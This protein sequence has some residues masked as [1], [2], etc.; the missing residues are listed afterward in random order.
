MS[1]KPAQ[2]SENNVIK[3]KAFA[4]YSW[5]TQG[6]SDRVLAWCERLVSD[7]V[8]VEIDRWSLREGDDKFAYME[9]MVTDP[10]ISHVLIFSDRRYA[11]R[12]NE[13]THGVG[14]ESQIISAELYGKVV[15]DKFIPIACELDEKGE[16]IMPVFLK[17]R[18]YVDFSSPEKANENWEKLLRRIY[19]KPSATKPQLGKTPAYLQ[20]GAA[21]ASPSA[22]KFLSLKDAFQ[23]GH[24]NPQIWIIDYLDTA[25]LHV[26]QYPLS[27]PAN[28]SVADAATMWENSLQLMLPL[29]NELVGFIEL[30]FSAQIPEAAADN[31][32]E[33][34]ERLVRLRFRDARDQPPFDPELISFF[35][36]EL[37][38]YAV[39]AGIRFKRFDSV[40]LLLD[41]RYVI[42]ENPHR[43]QRSQDFTVMASF[44]RLLSNHNKSSR[45]NRLSMEAD[46]IQKRATLPAYPL[47]SLIEADVICALRVMTHLD[48]YGRWS[49]VTAVY[50]EY[51]STLDLF[52]RAEENRLFRQ[53]ALVIDVVDK[54]DLESRIESFNQRCP[55]HFD[56]LFRH[57]DISLAQL[58]GVDRL[59]TRGT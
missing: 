15:Q 32:G 25:L 57:G 40:K 6:H 44:S 56:W 47:P 34:F 55:D 35:G 14:A 33:L 24:P 43:R 45:L 31:I 26:Q 41:R 18:I 36:H 22:S 42:P 17:G 46:L 2:P 5:T 12:A 10:A 48:N 37:F 28:V 3:V 9:R 49:P 23:R 4:S 1:T 19:G 30:M 16:A 7:G 50:A 51:L 52:V 20:E 39:A 59:A 54:A 11:E 53:L 29:R 13:R 8:D 38:L 21:P 58:I 27:F